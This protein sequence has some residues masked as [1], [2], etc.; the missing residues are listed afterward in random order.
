MDIIAN[1]IAK[2]TG[3]KRSPEQRAN[4]SAG[5]VGNTNFKG[6]SHSAETVAKMS[7]AAK[8]RG[9]SHFREN[10]CDAS[11]KKGAAS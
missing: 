5:Q 9:I 11:R 1:R 10:V 8:K 3:K 7:D 4:M 6:K 2:N